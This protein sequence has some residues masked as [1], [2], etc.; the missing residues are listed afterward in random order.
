MTKQQKG[1]TSAGQQRRSARPEQ[2]HASA[3]TE[4]FIKKFSENAVYA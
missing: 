2:M 1:K 4:T 3:S